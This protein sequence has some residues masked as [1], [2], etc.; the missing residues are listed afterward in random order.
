MASLQSIKMRQRPNSTR[1]LTQEENILSVTEI[2]K[3]RK[4]T[5]RVKTLL[6]LMA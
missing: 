1:Q 2:S 6:F 4:L 3:V 5:T